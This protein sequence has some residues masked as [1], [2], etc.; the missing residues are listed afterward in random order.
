MN[1]KDDV[2]SQE[3]DAQAI[4]ALAGL[5]GIDIPAPC[6]EGVAANL[7]L[8]AEHNKTLGAHP[9]EGPAHDAGA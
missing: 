9:P 5:I 7:Q 2:P 8:L 1:H 4:A 6:L 3:W